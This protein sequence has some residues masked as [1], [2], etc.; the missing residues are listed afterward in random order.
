M[1]VVLVGA[2][3]AAHHDRGGE[4]A[5]LGQGVPLVELDPRQVEPARAQLVLEGRRRLAGDVL[6]DEQR[7]THG[8]HGTGIK[9]EGH[10]VSS[11]P[12]HSPTTYD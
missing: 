12:P 6:E 9:V 4:L 10:A 2:H 7:V 11:A 3:R 1:S 5:P 8:G